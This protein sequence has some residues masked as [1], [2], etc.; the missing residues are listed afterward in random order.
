VVCLISRK[1]SPKALG[2]ST[3]AAKIEDAFVEGNT[4]SANGRRIWGEAG[5]ILLMF[6]CGLASRAYGFAGGTGEPNNPYQ[7]ATAADLLSIGSNSTLLSKSF[8]L[9][10][11][12]DLDPNLPG[13]RVFSGPLIGG[14][15]S[16]VFDGQGH[17]IHRLSIFRKDGQSA[18]L[19]AACGGLV[20]NLHLTD[21][22]VSGA[23]CGALAADIRMGGMIRRCSVTGQVTGSKYVGGLV[24]TVTDATLLACESRAD[25]AGDANSVAGG[26]AAY[27]S[28]YTCRVVECRADG[29]V[30]GGQAAGGLIGWSSWHALIVRCAAVGPVA[31]G[32]AAGGLIGRGFSSSSVIDCYA[33]GSVTGSVAGGLIGDGGAGF[34]TYILNS[35]AAGETLGVADGKTPPIVGGLLGKR[36]WVHPPYLIDGCFW[37]AQRSRVPVATGS[38]LADFGTGLATKQMQQRTTFEQA[39]WDFGYTWAMPEGDYPVLQ[40]ELAQGKND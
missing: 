24:G 31:A 36:D 26:L 29:V 9:I 35:Y 30:T 20:E 17:T 13:G 22:R 7:I 34:R 11:D 4:M 3:D 15:F 12:I 1:A 25:V 21:V 38:T 10:S 14:S 28:N 8:M 19:F 32:G 37:D 33:R 18:G 6:G 16:G 2:K 40:W 23:P 5:I 27:L 39:G